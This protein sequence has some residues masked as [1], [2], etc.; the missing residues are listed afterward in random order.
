MA[1]KTW[2]GSDGREA[3]RRQQDGSDSISS[4]AKKDL[5][6]KLWQDGSNSCDNTGVERT[7]IGSSVSNRNGRIERAATVTAPTWITGTEGIGGREAE[8]TS[9]QQQCRR[10][11]IGL[12]AWA[13]RR[14]G[15]SETAVE[16]I[17]ICVKGCFMMPETAVTTQWRIELDLAVASATV[18]EA[19]R[20]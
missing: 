11:K 10:S 14:R 19:A 15:D 9:R 8:E 7:W 20:W 12:A 16:Q 13:E 5:W 18:T 17:W 2:L 4:D 6:Q 3:V 1:E